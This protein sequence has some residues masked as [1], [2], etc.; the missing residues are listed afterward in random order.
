MW[1]RSCDTPR[2]SE[3]YGFGLKFVCSRVLW[4]CFRVGHE[5]WVDCLVFLMW[6]WHFEVVLQ[7]SLSMFVP[8][9]Q[10]AYFPLNLSNGL[11]REDYVLLMNMSFCQNT[12]SQYEWNRT[13]LRYCSVAL[14][15]SFQ[16]DAIRQRLVLSFALPRFLVERLLHLRGI[17]TSENLPRHQLATLLS[18]KLQI[19][20]H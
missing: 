8:I 20:T 12:S 1:R 4:Y 17:H 11:D 13:K 10:Y 5:W 14:G 15:S 7:S 2:G 6:S 3:W 9:F 18:C 16:N 19:E